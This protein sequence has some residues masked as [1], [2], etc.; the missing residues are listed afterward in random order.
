MTNLPL[1]ADQIALLEK[2]HLEFLNTAHELDRAATAFENIALMLP[3]Q[4]ILD[5]RQ[6]V[7]QAITKAKG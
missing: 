7:E 4:E 6:V 1:R 2:L 5:I 3:S